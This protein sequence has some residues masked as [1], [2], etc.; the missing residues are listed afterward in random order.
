MSLVLAASLPATL[1]KAAGE[2]VVR[3]GE[4][5]RYATNA[6]VATTNWSSPKDLVLVC[7]EGY[8]DAVSATV[9]AKRLDAPILLTNSKSLNENAK[10]ALDT[11]KPTNLYVIGGNASV[12]QSII[13]TL[14]NSSYNVIQLSGKNRY[15]TNVACC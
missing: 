8:A 10:N 15:E 14:K 7:G 2:N 1:V 4:T 11:L 3:V 13:N 6:K 9:L 12:S 5:D